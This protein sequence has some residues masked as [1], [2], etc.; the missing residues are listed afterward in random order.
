MLI[1]L[2][3][4]YF[5]KESDHYISQDEFAEIW[6]GSLK[7]DDCR[8]VDTRR[9]ESI[10]AIAKYVTKPG[11]LFEISKCSKIVDAM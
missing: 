1:V 6:R 7:V 8:V 10:A 2:S 3:I 11:R 5:D 9:L 4:K